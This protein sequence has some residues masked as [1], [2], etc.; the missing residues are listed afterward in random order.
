MARK[1]NKLLREDSRL[2]DEDV[3]TAQEKLSRIHEEV[4]ESEEELDDTSVLDT[5][6]MYDIEEEARTESER[7]DGRSAGKASKGKGGKTMSKSNK[8]DDWQPANTLSAP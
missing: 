8:D 3:E 5:D 6:D 7:H 2:D 1:I 4:H